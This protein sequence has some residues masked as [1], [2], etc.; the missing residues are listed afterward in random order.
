M[1]QEIIF[2]INKNKIN[3]SKSSKEKKSFGE[4]PN[5]WNF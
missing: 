1:N 4:K 2:A 5:L 3:K